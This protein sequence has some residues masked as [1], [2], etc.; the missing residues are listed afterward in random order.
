MGGHV[1]FIG[2]VRNAC[3]ILVRNLEVKRSLRTPRYR[4]KGNKMDLKETGCK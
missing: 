3:R 2:K 4:W 1:A